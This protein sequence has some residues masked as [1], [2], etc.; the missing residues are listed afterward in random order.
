MKI[1]AELDC[2]RCEGGGNYSEMAPCTTFGPDCGCYE[3]VLIDPCQDCNGTGLTSGQRGAD[4]NA[5]EIL[6]LR[7][8]LE[9]IT[10]MKS[11][12]LAIGT[13]SRA[14]G[15]APHPSLNAT[16]PHPKARR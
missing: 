6:R 7:L 14:L 15:G 3:R 9:D 4:A 10:R 13:A 5:P 16:A 1:M 12:D 11:I 8:Y 2:S